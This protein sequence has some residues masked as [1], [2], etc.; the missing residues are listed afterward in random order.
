MS[1][2]IELKTERLF[3]R[4]IR[5]QDVVDIYEYAQDEEW[6][7]YFNPHTL[8]YVETFVSNAV[9]A[10]W[11]T[12]PRFSIM[13]NSTLIG[14]TGLTI[15][16][17]NKR[18]E[19]GYSLARDHWGKGYATEAIERVVRWGFEDLGLNKIFAHADGGN[20]RSWR[21]M[22]KLGMSREGVFRNHSIVR[23]ELRNDVYYGLLREEWLARYL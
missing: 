4:P 12:S 17:E 2:P 1:E 15:D 20:R 23:G 9:M 10:P 16:S 8:N 11:D 5:L 6:A 14:G 18:A 3:L 19:L 22:E 21:V 7:R 13:L